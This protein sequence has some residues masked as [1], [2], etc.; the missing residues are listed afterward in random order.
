MFWAVGKVT[1][2]PKFYGIPFVLVFLAIRFQLLT[3]LIS[4]LN[5]FSLLS[6]LWP[7]QIDY[8]DLEQTA[9]V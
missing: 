4:P 5:C 3:I 2:P 8:I 6:G 1:H 9:R 7:I